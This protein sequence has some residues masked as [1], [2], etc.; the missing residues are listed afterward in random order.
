[1]LRELSRK[2][3]LKLISFICESVFEK[4]IHPPSQKIIMKIIAKLN[5]YL[6]CR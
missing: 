4:D 6:D 3:A 2:Q 5:F 1:M